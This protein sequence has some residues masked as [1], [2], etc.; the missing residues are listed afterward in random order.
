MVNRTKREQ[1]YK[2]AHPDKEYDSDKEDDDAAK[3]KEADNWELFKEH[4]EKG[5]GNK[6]R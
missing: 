4:N 3:K 6:M 1:A 5:A 2:K